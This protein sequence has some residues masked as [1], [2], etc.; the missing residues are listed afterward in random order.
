MPVDPATLQQINNAIFDLQSS[1]YNN[2]DKHIKKLSRL[3]HSTE[4]GF[5]YECAG[6]WN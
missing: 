1:D 5:D 6:C 3:L 4:T 2:F